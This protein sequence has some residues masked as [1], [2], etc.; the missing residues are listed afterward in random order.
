MLSCNTLVSMVSVRSRQ[1]YHICLTSMTDEPGRS[2]AE[3]I[4]LDVGEKERILGLII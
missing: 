1:R 3:C 4:I 2:G